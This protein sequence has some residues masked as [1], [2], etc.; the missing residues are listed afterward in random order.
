LAVKPVGTDGGV[1]LLLTV[2]VIP[3][4]VV[5]FPA[6]SFATAFNVCEPLLVATVFQE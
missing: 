6:V 3:A 5:L 2:T 1:V 4:L